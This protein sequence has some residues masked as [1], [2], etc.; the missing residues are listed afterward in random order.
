MARKRA[1]A[2]CGLDLCRLGRLL[3]VLAD[4]RTLPSHQSATRKMARN[5]ACL[6]AGWYLGDILLYSRRNHLPCADIRERVDHAAKLR[7]LWTTV[8]RNVQ[9][10]R[11]AGLRTDDAVDFDDYPVRCRLPH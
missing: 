4:R 10:P 5:E 6:R 11:P 3:R 8:L 7:R 9:E 1:V 2:W